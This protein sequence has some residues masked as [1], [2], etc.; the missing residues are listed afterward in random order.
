MAYLCKKVII[1]KKKKK[2]NPLAFIWIHIA[3]TLICL[4]HR[5]TGHPTPLNPK[6]YYF[7]FKVIFLDEKIYIYLTNK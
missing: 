4:L 3:R 1:L 5:L 2:Y 6:Q 7:G